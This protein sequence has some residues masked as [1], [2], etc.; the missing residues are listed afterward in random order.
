MFPTATG[1]AADDRN[2]GLTGAA[3]EMRVIEVRL[4]AW[5]SESFT[6][7]VTAADAG[8]I[9]A[10]GEELTVYTAALDPVPGEAA[11]PVGTVLDVFFSESDR[12]DGGAAVIAADIIPVG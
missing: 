7:V 4:V 11:Y 12:T 1:N 9:Y 5:Q 6:A 8:G 2:G 3:E 10:G